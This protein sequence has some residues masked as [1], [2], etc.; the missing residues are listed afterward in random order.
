ML[1]QMGPPETTIWEYPGEDR[2]WHAEWAHW[3]ECIEHKRRPSGDLEDA[4]ETLRVIGKLYEGSGGRKE[5][6]RSR[7]P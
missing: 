6:V 7:N 2:S 5:E 3:I 1:P 4:V